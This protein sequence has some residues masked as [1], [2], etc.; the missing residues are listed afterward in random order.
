MGYRTQEYTVEKTNDDGQKITETGE[1]ELAYGEDYAEENPGSI[2][3]LKPTHTSSGF[4]KEC[5]KDFDDD[6]V[7]RCTIGIKDE[8]GWTDAYVHESC[9]ESFTDHYEVNTFFGSA[10]KLCRS[11]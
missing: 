9:A 1:L 8:D 10:A 3:D 6:P 2:I 7:V 5:G 4:C 11:G